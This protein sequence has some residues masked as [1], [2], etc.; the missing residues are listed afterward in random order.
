MTIGDNTH[1]NPCQL[2]LNDM[3]YHVNCHAGF[4]ASFGTQFGV[5]NII[6]FLYRSLVS[7]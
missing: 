2:K 6:S 3:D 1:G 4:G 7:L 5:P